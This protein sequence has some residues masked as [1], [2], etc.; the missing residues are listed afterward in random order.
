MAAS[1][2]A[3]K[4]WQM[5]FSLMLA[6]LLAA[7]PQAPARATPT[8]EEAAELA[9][10]GQLARALETYRRLAGVN[11]RD[12]EARLAI[13]RLHMEMGHPD[14]AESVYRGVLFESPSSVKATVGLGWALTALGRSDHALEVLERAERG[15][16]EDPDVLAGLGRAYRDA[17]QTRRALDYLETAVA[18]APTPGN[19]ALLEETRRA[20][21]H[22][23]ESATYFESFSLPVADTRATDLT[24]NARLTDR[25]RL[26]GR[27]QLQRKF[28]ITE[29]RG[30]LGLEWRWRPDTTVAG[31][32][33][34]GPGNDVLP[35]V[36]GNVEVI[37]AYGPATWTVGLRH[38]QFSSADVSAFSPGV[39]WRH[40]DRL[41][42]GVRYHLSVTSFDLGLDA[43]VTQSGR[44]HAAYLVYPRV[45]MQAGY[46]R[47]IEDFD[48]LS[49]D[50]IGDFDAD[51]AS[52]GIRIDLR[53]LTSIVGAYEYQWRPDH[54]T[55]DRFTFSLVQRF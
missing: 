4:I 25:F 51:T 29:Q 30:G 41:T 54:T 45:W 26:M 33:L 7:A 28:G 14:L 27:G 9:Q 2:D 43:Q 48:T 44:V 12:Q 16:P 39:V 24:V 10:G 50:R 18:I 53:T 47:G 3:E 40:G 36:D 5:M 46:A 49:P 38:I 6:G 17:G 8:H 23:V 11:P 55:M 32:A 22:R 42:L 13:A 34:V 31:H 52:G 15:F 19:Q 20:H 37:Y 21:G 1:L 35:R